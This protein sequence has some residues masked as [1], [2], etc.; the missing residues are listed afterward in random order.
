MSNRA[1]TSRGHSLQNSWPLNVL[2]RTEQGESSVTVDRST[3]DWE[4]RDRSRSCR[5]VIAPAYSFPKQQVVKH[6]GGAEPHIETEDP[7]DVSEKHRIANGWSWGQSI[8]SSMTQAISSILDHVG[9]VLL[10]SHQKLVK[11]L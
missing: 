1:S 9:C 11:N 5:K 4:A 6:T 2:L 8:H 3:I 10:L 7:A